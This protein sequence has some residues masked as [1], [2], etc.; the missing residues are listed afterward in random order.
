MND[1]PKPDMSDLIARLHRNPAYLGAVEEMYEHERRV[2]QGLEPPPEA[3][4]V[5]DYIARLRAKHGDPMP[6]TIA[7]R[8]SGGCCRRHRGGS[9]DRSRAV[10]RG[11]HAA[12]RPAG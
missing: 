6:D 12:G 2:A 1:K 4:D 9:R 11:H 5:R 7:R 3:I 10:R 8:R